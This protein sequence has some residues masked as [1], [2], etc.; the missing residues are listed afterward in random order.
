MGIAERKER[1]KEQRRQA[2]IDA[3][4]KVFFTKGYDSSTMDDIA[5]AAELSKGTL[6]LY[7]QSKD[8][9]HF[10][11]MDRGNEILMGFMEKAIDPEK[12]GRE[13]LRFLGEAF[14]EFSNRYPEYFQAM[15][16]FQSRDVVQQKLNEQKLKKFIEGRS[17][18]SLLNAMVT[19]GIADGSVRN[20]LPVS[21]LTTLLWSQMMGILVMYSTKKPAF[22]YQQISRDQLVSIHLDLVRD[23]LKPRHTEDS[24]HE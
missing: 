10:E 16:F 17:S 4:E 14:V 5:E 11:I 6:Y 23:G 8:E 19:K 7:F 15:M 9:L 1:E 22:E 18:I 20:D 24:G 2:I 13:N 12:S 3:A 21:H